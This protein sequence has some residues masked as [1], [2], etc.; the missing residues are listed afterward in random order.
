MRENTAV[1]SVSGAIVAYV[2]VPLAKSRAERY[3]RK[4]QLRYD[5]FGSL[6]QFY[7]RHKQVGIEQTKANSLVPFQAFQQGRS[8]SRHPEG[9]RG[10]LVE[11]RTRLT[12]NPVRLKTA[13]GIRECGVERASHGIIFCNAAYG[14]SRIRSSSG[15]AF[16]WRSSTST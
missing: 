6:G 14:V 7:T 13:G 10:Q 12:L 5:L 2:T 9:S 16:M 15:R 4:S 3:R 8:K 11:H 1:F